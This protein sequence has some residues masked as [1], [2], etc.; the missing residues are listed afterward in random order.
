MTTKKLIEKAK[1]IY[2]N[3]KILQVKIYK[4]VNNKPKAIKCYKKLLYYLS[5]YINLVMLNL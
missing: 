4:L 1:C 2:I 5:F 3:I